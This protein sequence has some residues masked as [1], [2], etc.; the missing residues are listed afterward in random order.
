M[1]AFAQ[2]GIQSLY[3]PLKTALR[4]HLV[5]DMRAGCISLDSSGPVAL[6]KETIGPFT[7]AESIL[8]PVECL[9][10]A[11][12]SADRIKLIALD[13]EPSATAASWCRHF[14]PKTNLDRL[15]RNFVHSSLT[16]ERIKQAARQY[17]VETISY[18][19]EASKAPVYSTRCLFDR[20]GL[21]RYFSQ[22]TY[23]WGD[24]NS[25]NSEHCRILWP[26]EEAD[27]YSSS[28]HHDSAGRYNYIDSAG[29]EI[30]PIGVDILS[31]YGI[32]GFY[33]RSL[34]EYQS[35]AGPSST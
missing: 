27:T 21:S 22:S 18:V 2:S 19:H 31:R 5:N 15:C 6:I 33:K 29:A 35:Y 32:E 11:G 26:L 14:L 3:Q 8:N 23:D 17:G 34:F 25:L 7:V 1:N 4:L 10:D 13:R 16:C 12:F 24:Q 28:G 30:S 20:L 9:L